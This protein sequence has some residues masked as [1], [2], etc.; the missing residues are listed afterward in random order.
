M[1]KLTE[2]QRLGILEMIDFIL[3]DRINLSNLN[4]MD[5]I[6]LKNLLQ[7]GGGEK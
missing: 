3:N 4:Y 7:K 5:L 2:K 1:I 6:N